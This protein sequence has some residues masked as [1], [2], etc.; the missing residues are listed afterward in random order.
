[1]AEVTF[2]IY[3]YNPETGGNGRFQEFQVDWQSG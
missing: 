3:R 1:M 2:K